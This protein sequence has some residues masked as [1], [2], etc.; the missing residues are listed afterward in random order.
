VLGFLSLSPQAFSQG[1]WDPSLAFVALGGI[2]P[3]SFGFF[4]QVAPRMK[5]SQPS[6]HLAVPKWRIP[7]RTDVMNVRLIGGATLFGLGWGATVRLTCLNELASDAS[8]CR[9]W[10]VAASC[11]LAAQPLTLSRQCPGPVLVTTSAAV[12]PA[13]LGGAHTQ[14]RSL[15]VFLAALIAGGQLGALI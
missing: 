1:T 7:T 13:L 5:H 14:L 3:A 15:A 8:R 9:V 10:C 6:I 11:T 12:V 4:T 2:L